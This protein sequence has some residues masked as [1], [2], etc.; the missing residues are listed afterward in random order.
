MNEFAC[1]YLKKR[2]PSDANLLYVNFCDLF[3]FVSGGWGVGRGIQV[4]VSLRSLWLFA[5]EVKNHA[6]LVCV[7][8]SQTMRLL[9]TLASSWGRGIKD[10]FWGCCFLL[11]RSLNQ[12]EL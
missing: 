10:W 8:V 7:I 11:R 4:W 1:M 6:S 3:C 2:E 5:T 12:L 9:H